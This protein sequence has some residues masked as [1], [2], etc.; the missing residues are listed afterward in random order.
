MVS[1]PDCERVHIV[2]HDTVHDRQV[3]I[4]IRVVDVEPKAGL[5][6][7]GVRVDSAEVHY[8]RRVLADDEARSPIDV[9]AARIG[10]VVLPGIERDVRRARFPFG[11]TEI[12][13]LVGPRL[14]VGPGHEVRQITAH[15]EPVTRGLD[16]DVANPREGVRIGVG[17]VQ[18]VRVSEQADVG[19]G[20]YP[21]V[22]GGLGV[23]EPDRVQVPRPEYAPP[24]RPDIGVV[25]QAAVEL[26]VRVPQPCAGQVE[27]FAVRV[28]DGVAGPFDRQR[29]QQVIGDRPH[30]AGV[31]RRLRTVV[32]AVVRAHVVVHRAGA[33]GG[34]RALERA[35]VA[36]LADRVHRCLLPR[37]LVV[38][39]VENRE[40]HVVQRVDGINAVSIDDHRAARS[41]RRVADVPEDRR[42]PAESRAREQH[43]PEQREAYGH[44]HV[45]M[46]NAVNPMSNKAGSRA[47]G[48]GRQLLLH[49]ADYRPERG[50]VT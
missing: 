4:G 44:S 42:I 40:P 8:R 14:E 48:A 38:G 46:V 31:V 34:K 10:R 30:V 32:S 39:G 36:R 49:Q 17:L 18:P 45:E 23:S 41:S 35:V 12:P 27:P 50:R 33:R 13:A 9:E 26:P 15:D 16:V 28:V 3:G 24:R 25:G 43:G 22:G 2:N 19:H 37:R 20:V 29:C 1:W 21:G 5:P 7:A 6:R 47:S 11:R